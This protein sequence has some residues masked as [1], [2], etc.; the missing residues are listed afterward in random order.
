MQTIAGA[1]PS[2]LRIMLPVLLQLVTTYDTEVPKL[3]QSESINDMRAVTLQENMN[4][5]L[6]K[7]IKAWFAELTDEKL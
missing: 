2:N 5:L 4:T 6:K 7:Q 1:A 3:V